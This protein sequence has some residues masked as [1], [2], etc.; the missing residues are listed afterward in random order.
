MTSAGE[1]SSQQPRRRSSKT[2]THIQDNFESSRTL[3]DTSLAHKE[4]DMLPQNRYQ[5]L[6]KDKGPEVGRFRNFGWKKFA[7]GAAIFIAV[8]YL[9]GPRE[10]REQVL[11]S[12]K[13][14]C[15]YR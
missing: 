4:Q 7:I 2:S 5:K 15:E 6:D 10:R 14:P 9:F 13:N 3:S 8:I 1:S 12:I 11:S